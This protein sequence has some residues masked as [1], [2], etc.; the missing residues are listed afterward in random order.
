MT[1][2][3]V[4]DGASIAVVVLRSGSVG[5]VSFRDGVVELA[6]VRLVKV[7]KRGKTVVVGTRVIVVTDAGTTVAYVYNLFS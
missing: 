1:G 2:V 7:V 5:S 3:V 4:V 6:M